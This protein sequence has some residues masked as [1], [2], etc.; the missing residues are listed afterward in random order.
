M[1]GCFLSKV[2]W[3]Q[4]GKGLGK[5]KHILGLLDLDENLQLSLG[6]VC[7]LLSSSHLCH[8]SL[9]DFW[10]KGWLFITPFCGTTPYGTAIPDISL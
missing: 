7:F 6:F 8:M 1:S 3:K 9:Q 5:D 2:C 4:E 10:D